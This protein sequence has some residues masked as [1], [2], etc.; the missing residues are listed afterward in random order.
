MSV[1]KVQF[2]GIEG[3]GWPWSRQLPTLKHEWGDT[4]YLFSTSVGNRPDWLVVYDGWPSTGL[5][6]IVPVE[7]RILFCAEPKS[8]H[9]YQ[10]AYLNQFGHVVTSQTSVRHPGVIQT[11]VG[12]NWF[13]G[14]RFHLNSGQHEPVLRFSDFEAGNPPKNKLCSVVCSAKA[15]T[16]GHR[17]RLKFVNQ[18]KAELGE[19]VDV[20]GRGFRDMVDK[21]EALANYRYH[22]ALENSRHVDYWTEKVS[23]PF[24]RGCYP[25]YY[26]CP[27]LDNYF[28]KGS[29]TAID[30]RSPRAAISRI[31]EII[32][33][34]LDGQMRE[35][36]QEAKRRVLWEHNVFS[37]LERIYPKLEVAIKQESFLP[38]LVP[39]M[40]DHEAKRFKL[41]RRLMRPFRRLLGKP[42]R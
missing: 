22:I 7:R 21:D 14:V 17:E 39:L 9:R 13:V 6:T 33:S 1:R 20:F 19:Q 36:L 3:E 10:P 27:N 12:I 32:A 4:A 8:F 25:I 16:Q 18:L 30:I 15:V 42:P 29:F 23:D 41:S 28:P 35:E 2:V 11:Q 40:T 37:F 38:E 31:K 5:K 24:L 34:G 26:G